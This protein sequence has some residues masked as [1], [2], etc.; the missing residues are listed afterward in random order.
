M[1]RA[2][3]RPGGALVIGDS[4]RPEPGGQMS[5]TARSRACSSTPGATAA[6]SRRRRCA[7]GWRRPASRTSRCTERALAL[8]DGGD[9]AVI[10]L[11]G[12]TG[13]V[14]SALLRRLTAAGEPVRCLVRDPRRLGDQRV[15][16]QIALGDL[17]DPP[18]FR[19]ALRGV[20]TVVH[21]AASIRDQPR[22]LDRGAERGGDAAPGARG[23]ARRRAPLPVLLGDG[24][25]PS[26]AHAL[27]PREG[28]RPG[29]RAG[30]GARDDGV[31]ALDRLH[32]RRS[33]ADAAGA[34]LLPAGAA[35]VRLRAGG[36]QP[37]WAEDV[38][39]CRDGG[40]GP[41]GRAGE[42][43]SSPARDRSP[44]TRSCA[45]RSGGGRR[46]RSCTC[47]CRWCGPRSDAA[48]W[49]PARRSFATWEEAE[50]MEEPMA[51]DRE[52]RTRRRS[53]C[54]R[55]RW[56][57]CWRRP[58]TPRARRS[59]PSRSLRQSL[60]II[61]SMPPMPPGMPP[62]PFCSG[63]SAMIASVVRM[64]FPIDAA[65]CSAERVTMA[66]SMT[67]ADQVHDLAG[68]GVEAHVVALGAAHVVD[69]TEPSSP[70]L[71]AIWRS[72]SSSAR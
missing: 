19:N 18:S 14:G 57:R 59:G 12:A 4:A 47:R 3:L 25:R 23:R 55:A 8:A 27:L 68:V 71:S 39:D 54:A 35:G 22:R 36:Y 70:A 31:R 61:P 5:R 20:G 64:F 69:H 2:A 13:T 6:T 41:T 67:P 53:A 45:R 32:A 40:A 21:L 60:Y 65:F 56:R 26:L 63:I 66:G 15:R 50:L 46:R 42:P 58:E 16:V 48:P 72:G 29:G 10:L 7:A 17:A 62:P 34:L 1:A 11:T 38:A 37:I 43:S 28:A 30:V 33:M 9:R 51:T 49:W 52:R 44:T 24:R